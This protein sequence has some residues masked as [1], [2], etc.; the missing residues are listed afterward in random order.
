MLKEIKKDEL[1]KN[2]QNV[3]VEATWT[4]DSVNGLVFHVNPDTKVFVKDDGATIEP[5]AKEPEQIK[6]TETGP[7]FEEVEGVIMEESRGKRGRKKKT[8]KYEGK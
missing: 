2:T 7:T 3:F 4:N 6:P 5:R 8:N 1:D